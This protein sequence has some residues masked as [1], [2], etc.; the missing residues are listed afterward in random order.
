MAKRLSA[1]ESSVARRH[2]FSSML[3]EPLEETIA[4]DMETVT[5]DNAA[6]SNDASATGNGKNVFSIPVLRSI[7]KFIY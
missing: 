7:E 3:D 2:T 4:P 6:E 1:A 5:E